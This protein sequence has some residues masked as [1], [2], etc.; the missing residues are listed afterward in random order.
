MYSAPALL[1]AVLMAGCAGTGTIDTRAG[2][3]QTPSEHAEGPAVGGGSTAEPSKKGGDTPSG[4]S[5]DKKSD[6]K[7]SEKPSTKPSPTDS[8]APTKTPSSS[9]THAPKDTSDSNSKSRSHSGS[10]SKDDAKD[11]NVADKQLRYGDSGPDVT[12]MQKRLTSL[13]YWISGTDGQ[14][15]P[16]TQ[17]AVFAIQKVAGLSRDGVVGAKTRRAIDAGR[18]PSAR[19][20]SGRVVEVDLK[21]QLVML[22]DNG[23]VITILNTSTGS[24]NYYTSEGQRR[25]AVTPR[26]QFTVSRQID[27]PRQSKLGYLWRPKYFNGGIALHGEHND[28][29]AYASSHG[30]VRVTDAA[31]NWIWDTDQVPIGTKVWVY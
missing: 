19:S 13:G 6:D 20:T 26:G 14:F 11:E 24:G 31:M 12:A 3:P 16:T 10:D 22:V 9:P 7:S 8:P 5:E 27:G 17:Q 29:P 30:C 25:L 23:R 18:V 28:V 1:A 15:G 2:N 4:K 21:R